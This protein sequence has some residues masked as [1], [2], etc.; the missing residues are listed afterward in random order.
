M[1]IILPDAQ[2]GVTALLPSLTDAAFTGW[3][4]SLSEQEVDLFL[5]RFK[6]GFKKQLNDILTDM[7]MGIAFNEG[8]DFT[9]IADFPPLIIS[10]VTHQSFIET[11]EEGTEAAAATVVE[12][13]LTSAPPQTVIFNADHSFLYIIRETT[14]N[15]I[16]FMG[17]VCDPLA[18]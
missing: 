16:I 1:D 4:G 5:P 18:E 3:T 2:D 13:G 7:G 17:R 15:S 6:Y 12:V 9:G 10:K 14:T 11:N 8:A